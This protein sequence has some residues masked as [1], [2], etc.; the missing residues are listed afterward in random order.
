M[1]KKLILIS[2]FVLIIISFIT[3][4]TF[5]LIDNKS[6][7]KYF[8]NEL[9]SHWAKEQIEFLLEKNFIKGVLINGNLSLNLDA[10]ITR[11]D[12]IVLLVKILNYNETPSTNIS[13]TDISTNDDYYEAIKVAVSNGLISGYPDGSIKP[14][15]FLSRD[16]MATIIYNIEKKEKDL[17]CGNKEYSDVTRADWYYNSFEYSK[18]KSIINGY[19][20][21][22]FV[23]LNFLK[24]AE[25]FYIMAN[26]YKKIIANNDN[27]IVRGDELT[28]IAFK[29]DTSVFSNPER[30][31][32]TSMET[33]E[34][35]DTKYIKDNGISIVL[36]K[37]DL[38][39]FIQ[40]KISNE[41]LEE[42]QAAFEQ[43]RKSGVKVIFRAAYGFDDK[44][45]KEPSD[46]NITKGHILQLKNIFYDNED[47]LYCVQAGFLGPWGEWHSSV[48]GDVPSLAARKEILFS[49]LEAVPVSRMVQIRRPMFIRDI[50]ST[51]KGGALLDG[52]SAFSG[53]AL[54]RTAFHNDALLSTEIEYGTY[55]DP[56]FDRKAELEWTNNHNKYT[57]FGGE[58]NFLSS[59]SD[60][61]NA[62][63]ELLKLHAQFINLDYLE[64]VIDKWKNTT[65]RNEN[66]FD[67]ISKHLGYRF[68]IKSG[69][70]SSKIEA[71]KMLHI[72]LNIENIGFSSPTNERDIEMIITNG[73]QTYK[74]KINEDLRTWFRENGVMKKD[75]YFKLPSNLNAGLWD[76]Y[77]N[78]PDCGEELRNRPEYSIRIANQ[79]I[80]NNVNGY[81]L[82]K[83]GV[84]IEKSKSSYSSENF[85]QISKQEAAKLMESKLMESKDIKNE[86]SNVTIDELNSS[87]E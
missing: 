64:S 79:S 65:F 51:E 63:L 33:N 86:I 87:L 83:A 68:V 2:C 28:S 50:F 43:A 47:I 27:I 57:I 53:S 31:W 30:G 18:E 73:N 85:V 74:A 80:W 44:D 48:Y 82:L 37:L 13:F 9:Q 70:I 49:L 81:N 45:F 72:S 66:T 6:E 8:S 76:I 16:Q 3:F 19:P 7:L 84:K 11:A 41:K 39:Q 26:Y 71:G 17:V 24:R 21:N 38:K 10:P 52:K 35:L 59:Y 42:T 75:W 20:E 29:E 14:L 55:V 40:S 78:M 1:K 22:K 77:L 23:H 4:R 25:A 67:Y 56:S 54:S 58:T 5:K 32:Y 46:I 60:P 62:I 15:D 36:I 61:Q 34:K 12:F 69:G